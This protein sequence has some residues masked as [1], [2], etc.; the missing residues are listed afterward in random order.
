MEFDEYECKY[1]PFP[2]P[3]VLRMFS[4]ECLTSNTERGKGVVVLS[5]DG[6]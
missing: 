1:L 2:R 6:E 3:D 4:L 5:S